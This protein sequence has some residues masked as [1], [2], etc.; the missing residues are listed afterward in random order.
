[1]LKHTEDL[2]KTIYDELVARIEQKYESLPAREN[3][4]WYYVRFEEGSS[5][6]L[7]SKER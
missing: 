6:P 5:I 3:G 2:Q 7:L 1:M 4:Y